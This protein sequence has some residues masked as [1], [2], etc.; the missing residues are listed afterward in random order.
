MIIRLAHVEL[1]VGDLA[2]SRAFYV[3]ALGFGVAHA[4]SD[5]LCLRAVDE[6]DAW[7]LR[8][9]E[10]ERPGPAAPGVPPRQP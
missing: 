6:F 10:Q 9:C 4:S 1:A 3:D 2:A 5:A 8:L 7:S